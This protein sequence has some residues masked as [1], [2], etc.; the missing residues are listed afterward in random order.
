MPEQ[1]ACST[2]DGD[3]VSLSFEDTPQEL[4]EPA[5]VRRGVRRVLGALDGAG[6][7]A[8]D[9][10]ENLEILVGWADPA[11]RRA[12]VEDAE[13]GAVGMMD[14]TKISSSTR[15]ASGASIVSMSATIRLPDRCSQS[16][17][18]S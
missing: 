15:H 17:S 7:V 2:A 3:T 5:A 9:E 18:P 4:L 14:G 12:H 16:I 10:R 6:G 13:H 1:I 8:H 11:G